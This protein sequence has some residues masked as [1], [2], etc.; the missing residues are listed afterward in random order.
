[1]NSQKEWEWDQSGC[2]VQKCMPDPAMDLN[3]RVL[4]SMLNNEDRYG[5]I[6]Y[7]SQQQNDIKPWM[8][9][10]VTTWMLEV[11]EEQ[12]C[13]PYVF[14][15]SCSLLDRFLSVTKIKRSEL[16]L[17]GAACLLLGS[18][19]RETVTLKAEN[20]VIYTDN[21]I[22]LDQLLDMEL[23]ILLK[24]KWDIMVPTSK[25]FLL[26]LIKK[27]QLRKIVKNDDL[28]GIKTH[29]NTFIDLILL[30]DEF[31][32]TS[33]SAIAAC[34]LISAISGNPSWSNQPTNQ[35]SE[36]LKELICSDQDYFHSLYQSVHSSLERT[37]NRNESDESQDESSTDESSSKND[38]EYEKPA[39]GETTPTDVTQV[40]F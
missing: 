27:L 29:A 26:V 11:C 33:P 1:M 36:Y 13:E 15:L 5:H 7:F 32:I 24:L 16:Q 14:A 37:L 19:A 9:R 23:L 2:W 31:L 38:S 10:M 4:E 30:D 12:K 21:S 22:S 35:I 40:Y 3:P 17:L 20:L 34:C 25:D 39:S 8:R 28:E 18:K 6:N